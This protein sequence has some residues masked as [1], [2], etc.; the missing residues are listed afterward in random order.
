MLC[1]TTIVTGRF[2]AS[3][4]HWGQVLNVAIKRTVQDLTP[5]PVELGSVAVFWFAEPKKRPYPPQLYFN[6]SNT[7]KFAKN[8]KALFNI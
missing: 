8:R 3:V 1:L 4:Q 5:D 6:F 7:D 2:R